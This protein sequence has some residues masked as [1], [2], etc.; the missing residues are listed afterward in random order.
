MRLFLPEGHSVRDVVVTTYDLTADAVPPASGGVTFSGATMDL[1]LTFGGDIPGTGGSPIISLPM[2][3]TATVCLSTAS[4]PERRIPELYHLPT[5]AATAWE[6][7]GDDTGI[8]DDFVCGDTDTFSPFAVGYGA[9]PVV[10]IDDTDPLAAQIYQ[11]GQTVA[12]TLP[13]AVAA[14]NMG[15]LTY[16]LT[17]TDSIPAG[18][19]FVSA[20]RTLGGTPTTLTPL[21]TLTYTRHR[22]GLGNAI[23]RR[24]TLIGSRGI[25]FAWL[26]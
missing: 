26:S 19:S 1:A 6:T 15:M 21:V 18:L 14:D 5:A 12:L 8:I 9:P 17:P 22:R 20:T 23:T 10:T 13:P 2:G 4:V 24:I 7:I 25:V 3:T 16:T 11:V